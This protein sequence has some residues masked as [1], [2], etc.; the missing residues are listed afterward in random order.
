MLII[1]CIFFAIQSFASYVQEF[2]DRLL[3]AR[4]EQMRICA[5]ACCDRAVLDRLLIASTGVTVSPRLVVA[6]V[7]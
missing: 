1:Q 2:L 5:L 7:T 4:F 3:I 6:R